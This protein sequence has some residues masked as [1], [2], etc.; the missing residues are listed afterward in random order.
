MTQDS[1]LVKIRDLRFR[2]PGDG[3]DTLQIPELLIRPEENM[4][5]MGASGSGKSTLL[6]LIGGVSLPQQ[7]DLQVLGYDLTRMSAAARDRLRADHIGYIF[8]Q[9]NLIPYLNALENIVLPCRFSAARKQRVL[10][11]AGSLEAE[12]RRLFDHLFAEGRPDMH[13]PVYN[14]SVGQQQRIAA[15][16]AL[17]GSPELVIADEPTSSLDSDTREAFMELLLREVSE[18]H[19]SLLFVSHDRSLRRLF[20]NT[21]QLESVNRGESK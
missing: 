14:L 1:S 17:I 21:L 6:N 10:Q 19:S 9:F 4:F 12:A 15:A 3:H 8:Q 18:S 5:I 13:K 7:G 2:W 16:R 20:E 11:R